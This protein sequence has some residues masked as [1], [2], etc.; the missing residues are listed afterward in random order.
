MPIFAASGCDYGH[1]RARD[2]S[3]GHGPPPP[4]TPLTPVPTGTADQ[5]LVN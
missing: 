4:I 3:H 5:Q 1:Q 2:D